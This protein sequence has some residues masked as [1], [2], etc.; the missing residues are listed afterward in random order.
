M[1][2]NR[3]FRIIAKDTHSAMSCSC[4]L[5]MTSTAMAYRNIQ[6]F[7]LKICM[8]TMIPSQMYLHFTNQSSCVFINCP[9]CSVFSVVLCFSTCIWICLNGLGRIVQLVN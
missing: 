2:H 7:K 1:I 5:T 3:F 9:S 8:V 4:V 6:L